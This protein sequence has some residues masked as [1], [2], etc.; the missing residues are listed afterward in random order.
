MTPR[1]LLLVA[2]ALSVPAAARSEAPAP[3][4][5]PPRPPRAARLAR[6]DRDDHRPGRGLD[7]AR[8][9]AG[10]PPSVEDRREHRCRDPR[11]LRRV[12]LGSPGERAAGA[13]L[14]AALPPDPALAVGRP[15][16]PGRR[17]LARRA[18]PRAGGRWPR[19]APPG[20]PAGPRR[21]LRRAGGRPAALRD[22]SRG[23]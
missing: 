2:L 4:A 7:R 14:P 10:R 19:A 13:V 5:E 15:G 16:P 3:G 18:A 20:R 6:H 12:R 9:A 21:A 1:L 22:R 11:A 23:L 8:V 17:S